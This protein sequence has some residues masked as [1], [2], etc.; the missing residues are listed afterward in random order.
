MFVINDVNADCIAGMFTVTYKV[1]DA[2]GL[3]APGN[4]SYSH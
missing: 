4:S 2:K 3:D 1:L